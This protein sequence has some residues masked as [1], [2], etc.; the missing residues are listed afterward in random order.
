MQTVY[1]L[2]SERDAARRRVRELEEL[3][4]DASPDSAAYWQRKFFEDRRNLT[5]AHD[6][7][8]R[9]EGRPVHGSGT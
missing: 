9:L 4:A 1:R 3:L 7:I 5:A 2:R 8:A 6:T